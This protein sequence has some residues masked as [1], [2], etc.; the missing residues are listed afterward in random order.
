MSAARL[1]DSAIHYDVA[2][3]R[4]KSVDQVRHEQA[5]KLNE[6]RNSFCDG[7]DVRDLRYYAKETGK[8]LSWIIAHARFQEEGGIWGE[9]LENAIL[10]RDSDTLETI[11]LELT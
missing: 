9:F 6:F 7:F 2:A 1:P 11:F 4:V 8:S 5:V 10:N 3:A